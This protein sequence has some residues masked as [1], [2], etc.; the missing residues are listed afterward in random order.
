MAGTAYALQRN[1]DCAGTGDL[2]DQVNITDV[3]A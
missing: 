3:D 2:A 1:C